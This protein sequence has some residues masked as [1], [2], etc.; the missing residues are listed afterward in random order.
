MKKKD[1]KKANMVLGEA[2]SEMESIIAEMA[3]ENMAN[4]FTIE[5]A[6]GHMKIAESEIDRLNVIVNYLETRGMK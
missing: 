5:M 3:V 2:I 4:K 6:E 1:L